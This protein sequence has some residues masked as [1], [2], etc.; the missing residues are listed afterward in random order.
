MCLY[1]SLLVLLHVVLHRRRELERDSVLG[2]DRDR[3]P[4]AHVVAL[5]RGACL[6]AERS[7]ALEGDF[8]PVLEGLDDLVHERLTHLVHDGLGDARLFGDLRHQ[9]AFLHFR[10]DF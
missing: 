5:T 7:E 2:R 10:F 3:L 8:L 1:A 9:F 6:H 4:S